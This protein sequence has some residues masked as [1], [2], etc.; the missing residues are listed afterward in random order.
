MDDLTALRN[1]LEG[2]DPATDAAPTA[3]ARHRSR[4]DAIA[5]LKE[6]TPMTRPP[7]RRIPVLVAGAATAA[8][9]VGAAALMLPTNHP[10]GV[11]VAYAAPPEPIEVVGGD[12]V[13]GTGPLLELAEVA[14]GRGGP[15]GRGEVGFVSSTGTTL[16]RMNA[17]AGDEDP[18]ETHGYGFVPF[19]W[20]HW[21]DLEGEVRSESRPQPPTETGGEEGD[22]EWFLE[23]ISEIHEET[24]H[25]SLVLP[26]E[27]PTD[28]DEL[29]EVLTDLGQDPVEAQDP[30]AALFDSVTRLYG[31]RPLSGEEEAAVQR[32][33]ADRAEVSHL[34][35][36]T[37]PLNR[38]GELFSF[39]V[40][41]PGVQVLQYRYLYD[42]RDGSLL[43]SDTTLV[44]EHSPSTPIEDY[45]L[46]YPVLSSQVSY[47]WAGWVEEIGQRP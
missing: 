13:D 6:N 46:T 29:V 3:E 26:E 33:I 44:D 38:E 19:D 4:A 1:A 40:D 43:Y 39:V 12:P 34:G 8:L 24:L 45:G 9:A 25:P 18:E 11:P 15:K 28:P 14:A 32:L 7:W 17:N 36:A 23:Q 31:N 21:Q 22:H 41:E 2:T 27:L 20:D 47:V 5:R 35:T 42:A 10:A 16:Y 37:D 30:D